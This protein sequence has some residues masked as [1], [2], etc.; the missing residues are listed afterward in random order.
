LSEPSTKILCW[1]KQLRYAEVAQV[2]LEC[3]GVGASKRE[4]IEALGFH[5]GKTCGFCS[6]FP[7][8]YVA[9]AADQG[10]VWDDSPS[11]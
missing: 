7:A 9:V 8:P 6:D 5:V 1:C 10:V 2:A 11:P 3:A 4:F